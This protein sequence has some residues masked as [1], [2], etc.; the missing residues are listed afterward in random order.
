MLEK[1]IGSKQNRQ[2]P[3]NIHLLLTRVNSECLERG[4][5]IYI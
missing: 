5:Y 3:G 1:R 4:Q 2:N